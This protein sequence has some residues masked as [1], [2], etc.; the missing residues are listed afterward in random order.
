M[1]P[2]RLSKTSLAILS[3]K[4][5]IAINQDSLSKQAQLIRRYTEEEWDVWLGDLSGSRKVLGIANWKNQ[6]Q[7]INVDLSSIGITSA[8]ARDVW[9]AKDLGSVS[10]SQRIDL[11]G[12]E[13]KVWVLSNI[14]SASLPKSAGYYAAANATLGGS[15][16]IVSCASNECSP[17]Q[18]KVG[19][20]GSS[21]SVTFNSITTGSGGKK[22]LG[23]DFIHYDYAFQTAW[24]W[25]TNTRNM[26]ISVNGGRAKRW[27][28]PLSGGDWFETGRLTIEVDGFV[29]GKE[30]K[31]VFGTAKGDTWAP[32][33]VGFEIFE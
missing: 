1:D 21:A 13:M 26:T 15:A 29:S 4:E 8:S 32:D 12:H 22:L 28:F 5:V 3:N 2:K 11:A 18:K 9:G 30:N 23:V 17:T 24:D 7:S 14:V 25:G 31:V 6:S 20:I 27:A 16:N 33:L 10:G 19:N